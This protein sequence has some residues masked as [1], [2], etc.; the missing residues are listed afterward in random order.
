MNTMCGYLCLPWHERE[1]FSQHPN[2]EC[3]IYRYRYNSANAPA[4]GIV[5]KFSQLFP[6]IAIKLTRESVFIVVKA[7]LIHR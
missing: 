4:A 7:V 2:S 5:S 6:R 3:T 1:M